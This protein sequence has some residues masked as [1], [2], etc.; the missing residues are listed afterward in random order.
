VTSVRGPER[1]AVR[2]LDTAAV[3]GAF[4]LASD[5]FGSRVVHL[6]STLVLARLL[7]P[8][9]FGLMAMAAASTAFFR[10][11]ANLG[12]GAA[13][14]QRRD[15]DDEYLSTAYWANL[16]AGIL[17]FIAIAGLG[18]LLGT[19]LKEPRV[20][21]LVL[22]L[23]LRFVIAA[24]S[25]TQMAM[26][27]R[28]MD[29]RALSLR[30]ILATTVGGLFGIALAYRGLGVWSLVGQ[31][32]GRSIAGTILLYRAT[33]WRPKR[34]FSWPKF[35]DLW[36]FGGPLLITRFLGYLV[37][38][39]DN[40]LVG[41]YLGAAALGFYA[42]G[43][44]VFAAPLNDIGAIVQ[45]VMF[46]TLSRLHGDEDRFKRGFLMA[47]CYVSMIMM[48][49]MTGLALVG[50]LLVGV[51]FGSKWVPAAPVISILAVAGCFGLTTALGPT[52][53][54]ASG[55]PDLYLRR[56]LLSTLLYLP[57]FAVGIRWG[58]VGVA[59]GYLVATALLAPIGFRM[60]AQAT[61]VGLAEWWE[62]ISPG[63]FGSAVMAASVGLVKWVLDL[64]EFPT[65]AML[66]VL[67]VVGVA[68]YVASLWVIRRQ[69]VQGLVRVLRD[70]LHTRGGQLLTEAE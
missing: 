20:G 26:I 10:V 32:L 47:S 15:V 6:V 13:I 36:S 2:R 58:I 28:R 63:V 56:S 30:S 61:G 66:V 62:A 48:P 12:L 57:A 9:D 45:R 3:R 35:L 11:F 42:F 14:I 37:R 55:R 43:F 44:T 54:Q 49:M 50:P 68:V 67:V 5:Q 65:V 64:Q 8:T 69:A 23:S 27:S 22:V 46:S 16:A 53:L 33:G 59:T 25:A 51:M 52:G 29:F 24:G 34:V 70:T 38:N 39:T 60:V 31:E 1:P 17:L 18:E 40:L 4:W 19:F 7:F 41:R 21:A